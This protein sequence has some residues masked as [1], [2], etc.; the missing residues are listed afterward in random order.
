MAA[1]GSM[2]HSSLPGTG[3]LPAPAP[4]SP[5]MA[6]GPQRTLAVG[7]LGPTSPSLGGRHLGEPSCS[8]GTWG[9]RCHGHRWGDPSPA[10][11]SGSSSNGIGIA[12]VGRAAGTSCTA[13]FPSPPKLVALPDPGWGG[14]LATSAQFPFIWANPQAPGLICRLSS[15]SPQRS[16][17]KSQRGAENCIVAA[18][19]SQQGQ[20]SAPLGAAGAGTGSCSPTS[21]LEA[22]QGCSRPARVPFLTCCPEIGRNNGFLWITSRGEELPFIA[23][24]SPASLFAQ[25][26]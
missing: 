18:C 15:S 22:S 24:C 19:P 10:L 21:H 2:P 9:K 4:R 5:G 12:R 16:S 11:A 23:W 6:R 25:L 20:L 13:S 8:V 1:L 14:K 17:N 7:C 26:R 3:H